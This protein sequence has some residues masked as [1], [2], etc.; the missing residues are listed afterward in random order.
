V[1]KYGFFQG[2]RT[3]NGTTDD[4]SG[5]TTGGTTDGTRTR[6]IKN[7]N[8]RMSNKN[9]AAPPLLDSGGYGIEE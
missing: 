5:G 7:N 2:G 3:A 4:T 8:I 6:S 1:I 9:I